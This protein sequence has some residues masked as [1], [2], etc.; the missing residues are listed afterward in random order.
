M[1]CR[2][3]PPPTP[4]L[5]NACD[6]CNSAK[7]KC[8]Q[9]HPKCGRCGSRGLYCQYSVSL[10]SAK[11]RRPHSP[12]A[13]DGASM[14]PQSVTSANASLMLSYDPVMPSPE[15][16]GFVSPLLD[17]WNTDFTGS[18]GQTPYSDTGDESMAILSQFINPNNKLALQNPPSRSSRPHKA[19]QYPASDDNVSRMNSAIPSSTA[20][21]CQQ[22]ILSKLSELSVSSHVDSSVP[23]DRSLSENKKIIALC[24]SVVH[25]PNSQHEED[26]VLM[27]TSVALITHVIT[28][29]N[30][31]LRTHSRDSSRDSGAN[32]TASPEFTHS[33]SSTSSRET[34]PFTRVRLSLGS[35]QLDQKDEQIL[36]TNLLRIELSKIGGLI[37]SF[38]KRFCTLDYGWGIGAQYEPKPLGEVITYL[39]KR[40]RANYEALA[41]LAATM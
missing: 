34:E 28:I 4:Q 16:A 26:I 41:S 15:D 5:K 37:D 18:S 32:S 20:C 11:H 33:S 40:L 19:A 22:N 21:S 6:A 31:P 23:F 27:L 9:A 17:G 8:S 35:Y 13:F 30:H 3:E 14:H 1:A 36:Q 10:R 24:T 38:D 39:K 25:C 7:V 29:Y 2:L 12:E